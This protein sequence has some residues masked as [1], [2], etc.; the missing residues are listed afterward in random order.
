MTNNNKIK[1]VLNALESKKPRG[2]PK[3]IPR[4]P[5]AGK[6]P[7]NLSKKIKS[8][9]NKK[10]TINKS[11]ALKRELIALREEDVINVNKY[12]A[13]MEKLWEES[14]YKGSSTAARIWLEVYTSHISCDIKLM[15][16]S[17][18]DIEE[19]AQIV[20]D[21]MCAGHLSISQGKELMYTLHVRKNF[22]EAAL[23]RAAEQILEDEAN[24]TMKR[25]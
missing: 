5:L 22:R 8:I 14:V 7:K 10:G 20:I 11:T 3:G 19:A 23:T 15:V 6:P 16:K 24:K 9:F 18:E 1:E 2:R 12:T 17:M 25:R 21:K 13:I 4:S